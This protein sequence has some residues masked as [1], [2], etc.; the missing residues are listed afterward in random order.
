MVTDWPGSFH[1]Y[2]DPA[3]SRVVDRFALALYQVG[4][5]G[6]RWVYAG[7]H[8]F[9]IPNSV[10]NEEGAKALLEFLTSAD[11]QWHEAQHGALTVLKSVQKRLK[12]EKNPASLEG[13]RLQLLEQTMNSHM[14][15][16]PRFSKYPG[17]EEALGTSLQKGI[18]GDWSVDDA[19]HHAASEME[20]VLGSRLSVVSPQ[21]PVVGGVA[22]RGCFAGKI[23][24]SS[25]EGLTVNCE[26]SPVN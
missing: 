6:Q 10:R 12:A 16:P 21:L 11:A 2:R 1:R 19:L 26:L 25:R 13:R 24:R 17:V 9:V 3:K 15:L 18:T 20:K 14:L 22:G 23:D 4:P 5:S 8:N 7:G